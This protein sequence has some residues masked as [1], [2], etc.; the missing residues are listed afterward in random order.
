[1]FGP[2]RGPN[3][4]AYNVHWLGD[5]DVAGRR[6]K[7]DRKHFAQNRPSG[8]SEAGGRGTESTRKIEVNFMRDN[9]FFWRA[10][11]VAVDDQKQRKSTFLCPSPTIT[12]II[13]SSCSASRSLAP[14]F[15]GVS[16]IVRLNKGFYADSAQL[17]NVF[18]A[19]ISRSHS[20]R[21]PV[22]ADL[23]ERDIFTMDERTISS[24]KANTRAQNFP[25]PQIFVM[26]LCV[27]PIWLG[28]MKYCRTILGIKAWP[29]ETHIRSHER[30]THRTV[31]RYRA[32]CHTK[33]IDQLNWQ[34]DYFGCRHMQV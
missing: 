19:N 24:S 23:T 30:H 18:L 20:S 10:P 4:R 22:N 1:M 33:P 7:D 6:A 31:H 8:P 5:I 14:L 27:I 15:S 11:A 3:A 34:S 13:F 12:I 32:I 25:P 29:T 28:P 9:S 17:A 16:R 26:V 2:R 21:L